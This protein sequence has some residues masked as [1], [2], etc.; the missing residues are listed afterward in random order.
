LLK[1]KKRIRKKTSAKTFG[2]TAT[3]KTAKGYRL[4]ISTH[5]LIEK[6]QAMINGSKD[7]VISRALILYHNKLKNSGKKF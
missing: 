1:L 6:I 2:K 7:T 4:K 3:T 5:I